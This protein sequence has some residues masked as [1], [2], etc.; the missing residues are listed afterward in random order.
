MKILLNMSLF[1]GHSSIF[2]GRL[3]FIYISSHT[4][5]YFSPS[6]QTTRHCAE[7]WSHGVLTKRSLNLSEIEKPTAGPLKIRRFGS[8]ETIVVS[9]YLSF[10]GRSRSVNIPFVGADEEGLSKCYVFLF[11]MKNG[12]IWK[13]LQFHHVKKKEKYLG[14]VQRELV[15]W[16]SPRI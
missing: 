5:F 14:W 1:Q 3:M 4:V 15:G 8:L 2:G 16:K 12:T 10:L 11:K 9:G 6:F 13:S 7:Q